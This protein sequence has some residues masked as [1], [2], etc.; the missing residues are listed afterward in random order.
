[1]TKDRMNTNK[2]SIIIP[3]YNVKKYLSKCIDS[4]INQSYEN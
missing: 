2:I 1:M 3:V 4:V